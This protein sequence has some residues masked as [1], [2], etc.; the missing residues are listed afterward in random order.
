[1]PD[2]LSITDGCCRG[3]GPVSCD[4]ARRI[5]SP[6]SALWDGAMANPPP[7]R[8]CYP[9]EHLPSARLISLLMRPTGRPGAED[10]KGALLVSISL[11]PSLPPISCELREETLLRASLC[12]IS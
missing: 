12:Y 1:M 7:F 3:A 4:D 9:M 5:H 2:L 8:A 10:L 6:G 11:P